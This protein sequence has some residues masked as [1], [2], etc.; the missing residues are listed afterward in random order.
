[1]HVQ[2]GQ[3]TR[4][5]ARAWLTGT[6]DSV[7]APSES[8]RA[9]LTGTWDENALLSPASPEHGEH[10]W[11]TGFS[12]LVFPI[13]ATPASGDDDSSGSCFGWLLDFPGCFG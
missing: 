3:S 13:G 4:H 5:N 10:A 11:L 9:W 1:M 8:S 7:T 12:S 6:W 2:M